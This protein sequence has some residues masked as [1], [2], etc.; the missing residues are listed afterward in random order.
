[1]IEALLYWTRRI[2][3]AISRLQ[4]WKTWELKL[5]YKSHEQRDQESSSRSDQRHQENLS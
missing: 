5:N 3:K 4:Q 2:A 1:M